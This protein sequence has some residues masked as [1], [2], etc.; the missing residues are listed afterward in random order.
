MNKATNRSLM[1]SRALTSAEGH[2][3]LSF[4]FPTTPT[5]PLIELT[6][7][8]AS[9]SRADDDDEF[10]SRATITTPGMRCAT[11]D[12]RPLAFK[13]EIRRVQSTSLRG[14]CIICISLPLINHTLLSEGKAEGWSRERHFCNTGTRAGQ[15]RIHFR[16]VLRSHLRGATRLLNQNC[17][18]RDSVSKH[19]CGTRVARRMP[20]FLK[21]MCG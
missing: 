15:K 19:G 11:R 21:R 17:F 6:G 9:K 18:I 2:Q 16:S 13:I 1:A 12:E 20:S 3:E 14:L 10:A 8:D 4:G 5:A 7:P